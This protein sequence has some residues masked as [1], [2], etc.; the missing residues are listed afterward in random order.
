M[1]DFTR[2]LCGID[3]K[4]KGYLTRVQKPQLRI[5][6]NSSGLNK[7]PNKIHKNSKRRSKKSSSIREP[8]QFVSSIQTRVADFTRQLR[9]V[10]NRPVTVHQWAM[11]GEVTSTSSAAGLYSFSTVFTDLPDNANYSSAY[12]QYKIDSIEY[13]VLP[14][15]DK[16]QP[17]TAPAYAHCCVYHDYDDAASPANISSALSYAN[18]AILGPGEKHIRKIRPHIATAATTSGAASIVG[19]RNSPSDWFD[20]SS[21]AVPH[22]GLKIVV[23]QSNSTAVS[24]WFIWARITV[25]LRNQK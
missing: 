4:S 25:S 21:T 24:K 5:S 20:T 19:A 15:T 12:D 16:A 10:D 13:H 9:S 3:R 11:Y 17:G 8:A 6:Q 1:R 23:Q 18:L 2:L 7:A 22:Y 14:V